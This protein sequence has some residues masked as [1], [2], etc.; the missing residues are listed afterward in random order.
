MK[1]FYRI[2]EVEEER[3]QSGKRYVEFLRIPVMSAGLY[4][5]PPGGSDPQK[6]MGRNPHEA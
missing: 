1:H 4:V 3:R 6:P 5:L 2:S